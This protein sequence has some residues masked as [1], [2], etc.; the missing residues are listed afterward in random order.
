[1]VLGADGFGYSDTRP[2]ARRQFLIDS[3]SM[4]VKTLQAL[5]ARGEVDADAPRQAAERYRLHDVNAGESG[6]AGGDS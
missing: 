3:H 4:V 2:A 1:M 5:A 6:T